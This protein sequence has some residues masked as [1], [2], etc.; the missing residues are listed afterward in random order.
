VLLL[1]TIGVGTYFW[2]KA[3]KAKVIIPPTS[4]V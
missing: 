4:A 2:L 3:K 1:T